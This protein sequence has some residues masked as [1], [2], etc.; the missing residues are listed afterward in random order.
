MR[1]SWYGSAASAIVVGVL[2]VLAGCGSVTDDD[3]VAPDESEI[4][5]TVEDFTLTLPTGTCTATVWPQVFTAFVVNKDAQ[6]LNDIQVTFRLS[7]NLF[8]FLDRDGNVLGQDP[9][10]G[11]SEIVRSTNDNGAVDIIVGIPNCVLNATDLM[12]VSGT[13]FATVRLEV[14]EGS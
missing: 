4:I 13:A 5:F 10:L 6:P 14:A 8:V 7:H 11:I 9:V 1:R 2:L 12:A 3:L